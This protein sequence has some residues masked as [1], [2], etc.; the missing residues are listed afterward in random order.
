MLFLYSD[1]GPDHRLTFIT[2]QL[3]LI[4]LFLHLNLDILVAARTAPSHSW[5]NPVERIMSIVN[6]GMQCVGV[7][8]EQV[9][10]KFEKAAEKFKSLKDLRQHCSHY[11]S[12]VAKSVKTPRDLIAS[13]MVRL[14][15]KGKKFKVF[16]S[17]SDA[18]IDEFFHVLLKIDASLS[19]DVHTTKK[20]IESP[21]FSAVF[22]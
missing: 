2:V 5:A 6:L 13:I 7:M 3:S 8:R 18:D 11:K 16:E 15:L 1:G 14:Q 19:P 20:S 4:A 9:S 12:D 17:S 22:F 21:C 10:E